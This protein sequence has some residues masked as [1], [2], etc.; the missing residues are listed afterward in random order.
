[1]QYSID[2]VLSSRPTARLSPLIRGSSLAALNLRLSA[3][4]P[5]QT[6]QPRH[7][8]AIPPIPA[9]SLHSTVAAAP[10]PALLCLTP[11]AVVR[12][13]GF[14]GMRHQAG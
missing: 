1:M 10:T 13:I 9:A 3:S 2:A 12:N 4:R 5:Y 14:T 7:L 6:C 8:L 11:S